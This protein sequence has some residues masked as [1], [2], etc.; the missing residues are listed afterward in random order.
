MQIYALAKLIIILA[1][2]C[3]L[4][5]EHSPVGLWNFEGNLNLE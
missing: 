2:Y 1:Y 3:K 5:L 4:G